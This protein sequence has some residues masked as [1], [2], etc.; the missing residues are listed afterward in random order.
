MASTTNGWMVPGK[1]SQL[2]TSFWG[3]TAE[4]LQEIPGN[5]LT[6]LNIGSNLLL[7]RLRYDYRW[8]YSELILHVIYL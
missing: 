3:T 1:V 6:D 8:H 5:K 4:V 7:M 2:I